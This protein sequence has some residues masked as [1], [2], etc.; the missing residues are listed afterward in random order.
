MRVYPAARR[1]GVGGRYGTTEPP[2]L[3]VRVTAPAVDGKANEA[4]LG[5]VAAAF[6]VPRRN[7]RMVSGWR[8]RTKVVEI[9]DADQRLLAAL[10]TDVRSHGDRTGG[11]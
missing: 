1:P 5:S 6:D 3:V 9:D 7:V 2:V 8:N 4:V 10:L 11:A